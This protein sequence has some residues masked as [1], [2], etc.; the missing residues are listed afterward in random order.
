MHTVTSLYTEVQKTFPFGGVWSLGSTDTAF[1]QD[2]RRIWLVQECTC[3]LSRW[4]PHVFPIII[5][6]VPLHLAWKCKSD[7]L[8]NYQPNGGQRNSLSFSQ[9]FLLLMVGG[10]RGVYK[11]IHEIN[12]LFYSAGINYNVSG[13]ICA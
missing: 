4:L 5:S 10:G 13:R 6:R 12:F 8:F 7:M 2:S 11:Q 9:P 1:G 3:S